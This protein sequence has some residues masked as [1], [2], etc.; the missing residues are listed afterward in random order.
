MHVFDA[1]SVLAPIESG[2]S[3][4]GKAPVV[5]RFSLLQ[6]ESAIVGR[7]PAAQSLNKLC[8]L[9][10]TLR[11]AF[12]S[13]WNPPSQVLLS[14]SGSCCCTTRHA[15]LYRAFYPAV[16][17]S[18]CTVSLLRICIPRTLRFLQRDPPPHLPPPPPPPSPRPH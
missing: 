16:F 7:T 3:C 6:Q 2:R 17:P 12:V 8:S 4:Y 18:M 5:R 9:A 14:A 15:Q 11:F 13:C 10:L 1:L